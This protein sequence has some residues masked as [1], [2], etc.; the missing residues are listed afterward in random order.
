MS[1]EE[2]SAGSEGWSLAGGIVDAPKVGSDKVGPVT[3]E[4]SEDAPEG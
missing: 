1:T 2:S 4:M 3:A